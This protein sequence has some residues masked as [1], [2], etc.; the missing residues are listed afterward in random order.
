MNMQEIECSKSQLECLLN[1]CIKDLDAGI[2]ITLHVEKYELELTKI[3]NVLLSENQGA[4]EEFLMIA[5]GLLFWDKLVQKRLLKPENPKKRYSN[6]GG[7][8]DIEDYKQTV[9]ELVKYY[10]EKLSLFKSAVISKDINAVTSPIKWLRF[11]EANG[12]E[13]DNFFKIAVINN[14]Y[15]LNQEIANA[16][17]SPS[18]TLTRFELAQKLGMN[19]NDAIK[20]CLDNP[21]IGIYVKCGIKGASFFDSSDPFTKT[22]V[23]I[24][25]S[26]VPTPMCRKTTAIQVAIDNQTI[27]E[28][29]RYDYKGYARLIKSGCEACHDQMAINLYEGRTIKIKPNNK[30]FLQLS[31]YDYIIGADKYLY[32]SNEIEITLDDLF[33]MEEEVFPFYKNNRFDWDNF[34]IESN[35]K[36][37]ENLLDRDSISIAELSTSFFPRSVSFPSDP[38]GFCPQ[39]ATTPDEILKFFKNEFESWESNRFEAMLSNSTEINRSIRG[40]LLIKS[41]PAVQILL[42]AGLLPKEIKR[43]PRFFSQQIDFEINPTYYESYGY[44]YGEHIDAA[45]KDIIKSKANY[46]SQTPRYLSYTELKEKWI[47]MG[48]ANNEIAVLCLEKKLNAY[49]HVAEKHVIISFQDQHISICRQKNCGNSSYLKRYEGLEKLIIRDNPLGHCC[50]LNNLFS[51]DSSSIQIRNDIRHSI[52][53]Q[54]TDIETKFHIQRKLSSLN[55]KN[56]INK[57]DLVFLV[58][59]VENIES[60][61]DNKDKTI[62]S[63]RNFQDREVL[64]FHKN[65]KVGEKRRKDCSRFGKI[66]GTDRKQDANKEWQPR[67]KDALDK[68]KENQGK[69]TA[70][71]LAR[72]LIQE[73]YPNVKQ[74]TFRKKISTDGE[75]SKC[76]K[77][78]SKNSSNE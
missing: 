62:Q 15:G 68:A 76:L 77:P 14:Y 41:E 18:R 69:F 33:F 30:L 64:E 48:K 51:S 7:D 29:H 26:L 11:A 13:I 52:D 10:V 4:L 46:Y 8:L 39:A 23:N 6:G 53:L 67:L 47:N 65:A 16:K 63:G 71:D 21:N 38:Q 5:V 2:G 22:K 73:K 19:E 42:N 9:A 66:R 49:L 75:I 55:G 37:I 27:A 44:K 57:E 36:I 54:S 59:E 25:A 32:A 74:D 31:L 58:E 43:L 78:T 60:N 24:E 56:I 72:V 70:T 28:G 12:L 17:L 35:A 3:L 45:L 61:F 50:D 34:Y 1:E 40:A 20:F